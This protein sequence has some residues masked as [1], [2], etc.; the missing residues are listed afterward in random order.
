MA[1]H[2]AEE[3]AKWF[4]AHNKYVLDT[5]DAD[6]I[7]NLKLQKL[8]YYAQGTFLAV[9]DEP[10]FDEPIIAWMH[11]PVVESIYHKYKEFGS[12]GIIFVESFDFEAFNKQE[13][14][15]LE[16]VYEEF[17][18]YSAWKLRNMTHEEDPWKKTAQ[19]EEIDRDLIKNYFKQVYMENDS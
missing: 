6:L 7:S 13:E 2:T 15:L 12:N 3:V 19:C 10:L 9:T 8:L 18:Q 17:G 14:A 5:E 11:G 4:L 16:E 1:N